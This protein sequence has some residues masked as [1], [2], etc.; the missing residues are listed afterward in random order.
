MR[1]RNGGEHA[2]QLNMS[3]RFRIACVFA[4]SVVLA[5]C[6]TPGGLHPTGKTL[7]ASSLKSEQSFVNVPLSP[8]AWPA[9]IVLQRFVDQ[10]AKLRIAEALPPVLRRPS[11]REA[12]AG[13]CRYGLRGALAAGGVGSRR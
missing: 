6:A 11:A 3:F 8:T 5:G 7:D 4:L 13:D 12:G 10:R 2:M 9:G 1:W